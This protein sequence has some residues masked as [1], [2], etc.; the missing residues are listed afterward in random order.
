LLFLS[1][2]DDILAVL[3]LGIVT[4]LQSGESSASP[5]FAH[6]RSRRGRGQSWPRCRRVFAR[7]Y[8]LIVAMSL[9][10]AMITP[11]VLAALLRPNRSK[12]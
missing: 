10:T 9:L 1:T 8:A 2:V 6:R 3:L 11:P 4:A 5:N 12:K 7:T